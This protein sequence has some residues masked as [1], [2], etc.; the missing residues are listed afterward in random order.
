MTC[1]NCGRY[2]FCKKI[3]KPTQPACEEFIK[4]KLEVK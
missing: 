2:P 4:R 3:E 1:V